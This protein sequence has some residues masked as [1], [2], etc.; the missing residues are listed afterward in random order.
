M[1]SKVIK[2]TLFQYTYTL[3]LM[4]VVL[5][6]KWQVPFFVPT[7]ALC[8]LKQKGAQRFISLLQM[9]T[10][11]T[12]CT[13]RVCFFAHTQGQLRE[14]IPESLEETAQLKERLLADMF[15]NPIYA[16]KL[17]QLLSVMTP[18]QA[19]EVVSLEASVG[20]VHSFVTVCSAAAAAART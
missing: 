14:Q 12:G 19:S 11:K 13:R 16:N 17:Q 7:S 18:A 1:W 3:L 20:R 10:L 2:F 15:T 9:C 8:A 5:C 6:V 4:A